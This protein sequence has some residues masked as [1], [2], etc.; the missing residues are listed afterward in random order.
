[1]EPAF[2]RDWTRRNQNTPWERAKE[3]IRDS[4]EGMTDH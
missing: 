1:V 3:S 2:E 4:W